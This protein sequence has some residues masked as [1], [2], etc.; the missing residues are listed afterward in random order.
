MQYTDFPPCPYFLQ[1]LRHFPDAAMLYYKLW[2]SRNHDNK[3]SIK[4]DDI[5]SIFLVSPTIFRNR[6]VN[7]MEEGLLSFETT[8]KFYYIDFVPFDEV[9]TNDDRYEFS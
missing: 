3:L 4:K 5:F 8:P 2:G 1:V 9:D 6:I 7:L